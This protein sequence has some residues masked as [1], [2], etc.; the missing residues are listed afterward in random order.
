M[1]TIR[2]NLLP[3]ISDSGMN[4]ISN[5]VYPVRPHH[6]LTTEVER[7]RIKLINDLLLNFRQQAEV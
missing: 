3:Q 1:T 5:A 4:Q 2:N 7:W 6:R